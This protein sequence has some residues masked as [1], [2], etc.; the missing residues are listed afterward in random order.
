MI[1]IVIVNWNSGPYLK[2]CLQSIYNCHS[3]VVNNIIVIDNASTDDSIDRAEFIYSDSCSIL[4]VNNKSNIGF[5]AACNQGF[6]LAKSEYVLFLNP[7]AQLM[8]ETLLNTLEFM[9]APE[10]KIYK[11]CGVCNVDSSGKENG[12]AYNFP[13][14]LYFLGKSIGLSNVFP[15]FFGAHE[16][17]FVDLKKDRDVDQVIGAYFLVRSEHFRKLGMFDERFFVYFEEVDYS[18]RVSLL[19]G[20]TRYLYSAKVLHVGGGSTSNV[21]PFRLYLSLKSRLL[22]GLKNFTA[23][24][25]ILLLFTTLLIEPFSRSIYGLYHEGLSGFLGVINAYKRLILDMPKIFGLN[26]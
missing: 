2:N 26:K 19:G 9:R 23:F 15:N 17:P 8:P 4:L 13:S 24:Q 16:I 10:N 18:L 12:S 7:D 3:N 20:K 6:N 1:D 22:Y 11:I 21:K 25:N 5:S 14:A